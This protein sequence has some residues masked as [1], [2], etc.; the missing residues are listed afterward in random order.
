MLPNQ[1]K[2]RNQII[3]SL[4]HLVSCR[5]LFGNLRLSFQFSGLSHSKTSDELKL[6]SNNV[7]VVGLRGS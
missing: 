2:S 1:F 5:R 3:V 7:G 4:D 6:V